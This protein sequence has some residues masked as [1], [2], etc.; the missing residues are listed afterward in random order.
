ME[1]STASSPRSP[2]RPTNVDAD[3]MPDRFDPDLGFSHR[4]FSWALAARSGR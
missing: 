1:S 3:F 2:Q 4:P